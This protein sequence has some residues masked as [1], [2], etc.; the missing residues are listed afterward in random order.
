MKSLRLFLFLIVLTIS[1]CQKETKNWNIEISQPL[2]EVK[3]TDISAAF[4][5]P[6]VSLAEFQKAYP[7]FQGSVSDEDY[8]KRRSDSTEINIYKKAK[9]LIN[10][11]QLKKDLAQLFAHIQHYF[12]KFSAP[13]VFL[14]SSALQGIDMPVFYRE[15]ENWLFIDITAFM[16]EG[17]PYYQGIDT[18]LQHSMNPQNL[19]PKVS[20]TLAEQ[21]VPWDR[22]HRKFIDMMAYEGKLMILQDAFLPQTSDALKIGYTPEQE[23]WAKENEAEIWNYFVENDLI[24]SDDVRLVDRFLSPAPFSKFYTEID[25]QS[26]PQIGIFSGWQMCRAYFKE[27][28]ETSLSDFIFKTDGATILKES[29]YKGEK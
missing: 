10:Q 12:P 29:H 21:I 19:V 22:N 28:P 26:A 11:P 23:A 18:Y 15:K 2:P 24:F 17:N 3:I 27:K 7:W 25:N 6:E 5:N 8:L 16:G 13:Q 9:T 1:S 4:Y 20:K 14:Y